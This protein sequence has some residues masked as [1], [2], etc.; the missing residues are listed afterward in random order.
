[1]RKLFP[2][3][4]MILISCIDPYKIELP[5]GERFLTVEGIIT[6]ERGPHAIILTR[7]D[8]YGSIFEGLIRPVTQATVV[9]RDNEGIST[10]LTEHP[11]GIYRTPADFRA[12][13]GKSY[14]LQIELIDGATY[15]SLPERVFP[16]TPLDN[17]SIRNLRIPTEDRLDFKYGVQLNAQ[18]KDPGDQTNQYFWRLLPSTYKLITNPELFTNGPTHP[19]NP[20]GP[21]PKDCCNT[22]YMVES[23]TNQFHVASDEFFNGVNTQETVA[24]IEDNGR[25]FRDTYRAD[26]QQVSVTP[27]AYRFLRLVLQQIQ[28]SGSVF[29][30]PP[31]N[32]RG[33][34][35]SLTNPDEV[36]LGYFMAGASSVKR[37]YIT[38]SELEFKATPAIIPDDC[39][40]VPGATTI[41]PEDWA[42]N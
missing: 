16:V 38:N 1:M 12:I 26:V 14:T 10:F 29:D 19:T 23:L 27:G 24:F 33:N 9:I 11:G 6:T 41:T 32:I 22:C 2:I 7:S 3:L 25:R 37:L 20:R 13:V 34:M 30:Q 40:E 21:A 31:A 35:I 39:R 5:E 4:L 42:G 15:T 18:F 8:T 28:I 17:V 36:V